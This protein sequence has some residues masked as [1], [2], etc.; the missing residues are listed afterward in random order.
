MEGIKIIPELLKLPIKI[1]VAL[2]IACGIIILIPDNLANKLYM[3]NF[4]ND[5]GFILGIVFV[6]TLSISLCY[7]IFYIVPIIWKKIFSKRENEKIKKGMKK[8]LNDLN[9]NELEIIKELIRQ[10]DNTLL[11]PY[12]TGIV[13]KLSHYGVISPV[14][15]TNYVD[16]L[17]PRIP[18]F[19]QPWVFN[20]FDDSGNL[21]REKVQDE[22]Q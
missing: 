7:F 9:E 15:S 16:L 14:S 22:K 11:L 10:P 1:I 21:L 18:Y 13:S 12:N 19:L 4:R 5:Y 3:V 20:Y 2:C 6:I 8:F 17:D